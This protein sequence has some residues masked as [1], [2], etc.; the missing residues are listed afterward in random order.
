LIAQVLGTDVSLSKGATVKSTVANVGITV[1]QAAS[2]STIL[3]VS[4]TVRVIVSS[5]IHVTCS[6]IFLE[7]I[8]IKVHIEVG[9]RLQSQE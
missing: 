2:K 8:E 6:D 1:I 4:K 7:M 5:C 3:V 9:E